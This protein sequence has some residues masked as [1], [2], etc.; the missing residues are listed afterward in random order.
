MLSGIF[1]PSL[2]HRTEPESGAM[3][4][5]RSNKNASK[6]QSGTGNCTHCVFVRTLYD[7]L[8]MFEGLSIGPTYVL[9]DL[10]AKLF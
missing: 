4:V 7:M 3:Y 5:V 1:L 8:M 10:R 2:N 6:C 9:T